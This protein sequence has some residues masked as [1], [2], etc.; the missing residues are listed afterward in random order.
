MLFQLFGIVFTH[1]P[2]T[3]CFSQKLILFANKVFLFCLLVL[4]SMSIPCTLQE[5]LNFTPGNSVAH[6]RFL[7]LITAIER[8]TLLKGFDLCFEIKD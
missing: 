2:H 1:W 6:I 7:A 4:G 3:Q 8:G 5:Y